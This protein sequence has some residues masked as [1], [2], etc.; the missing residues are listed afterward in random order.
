MHLFYFTISIY[1][2]VYFLCFFF[3]PHYKISDYKHISNLFTE[4]LLYIILVEEKNLPTCDGSWL[5]LLK[6]GVTVPSQ[7]FGTTQSALSIEWQRNIELEPWA[8]YNAICLRDTSPVTPISHLRFH[9]TGTSN[10]TTTPRPFSWIALA[11]I[12]SKELIVEI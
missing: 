12:Q 5:I 7:Y 6:P 3:I 11:S 2:S 1:A 8:Q 4:V 10:R 9:H